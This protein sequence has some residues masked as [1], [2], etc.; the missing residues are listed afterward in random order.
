MTEYP[1]L[2]I[3]GAPKCGTSALHAA[4]S[5]VPGVF[6]SE[7]KETGFFLVDEFYGRGLGSYV[8]SYFR[9][10]GGAR[11][12]GESTPWYMF[13]EIALSRIARDLPA[14]EAAIILV[15]DP[16]DRA[17]SMYRDQVGAGV[18]RRSAEVAFRSELALLSAGEHYPRREQRYLEHGR[19]E[20]F[21]EATRSRLG[22]KLIVLPAVG[23][24]NNSIL[25]S[26]LAKELA[27]DLGQERLSE[28]DAATSNASGRVRFGRSL[29]K[30]SKVLSRYP[31]VRRVIRHVVPQGADQKL[32]QSLRRRLTVHAAAPKSQISE[33]LRAQLER[34][35]APTLEF[36]A[37]EYDINFS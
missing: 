18:E 8:E 20:R 4:L 28:L 10:S 14:L 15:R 29:M 7:V 27:W 11:W 23:A 3:L 34:F 1:N 13:S 6:M 26:A 9:G 22:A 21:V 36:L 35:Y 30:L 32:M 37:T 19:Y 12:T 17:L 5:R 31:V 33:D 2:L 25:W 24:V 16:V